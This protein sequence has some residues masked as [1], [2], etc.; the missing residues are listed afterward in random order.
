MKNSWLLLA[1]LL[2]GCGS[3]PSTPAVVKPETV[4]LPP[5]PADVMVQREADFLKKL[6]DFLS[7]K[8]VEP[9]K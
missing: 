8:P 4:K 7:E 9:T 2:A 1:L 3:T 6:L 5:P